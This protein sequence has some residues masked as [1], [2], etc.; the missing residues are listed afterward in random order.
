MSNTNDA[1][2]TKRKGLYTAKSFIKEFVEYHTEHNS[3]RF[4]SATE[5]AEPGYSTD[6]EYILFSNWN[7]QPLA[8]MCKLPWKNTYIGSSIDHEAIEF[9]ARI[10]DKLNRLKKVLETHA[11]LEWDD[12]WITAFSNGI[13]KAVRISADSY[14]WMS[15]YI[16]STNF[17]DCEVTLFSDVEN[18]KDLRDSY[19][20]YI[21]NNPSVYCQPKLPL[22]A[23]GF[24]KF[25]DYESG[26]HK[27]QTDNPNNIMRE[28]IKNNPTKE[29]IF[30]NMKA[31]QFYLEWEL[32]GRDKTD[33]IEE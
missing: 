20:E 32:W 13:T 33:E 16:M 28:A 6:K 2:K 15:C 27:G 5:Y 29:F 30:T 25:F 1:I 9:N 31:S 10:V 24:V 12:E 3:G 17:N 26:Y 19:L 7:N 22:E 21:I 18:D 4:D 8:S 14:D 23:L 11:E